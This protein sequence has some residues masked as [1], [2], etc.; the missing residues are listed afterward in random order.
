MVGRDGRPL[1]DPNRREEGLLLP[2][3]GAKG[4]GLALAI[5]LLAGTLNGAAL[6]RGVVDFTKET[7]SATNT[8]QFV[9]AIKL[10]AFADP[11]LFGRTVDAVFEQ[12]RASAPLPGHDPVRIPGERREAT[13]RER[14]AAGIP[15][16]PNLW[17]ELA[18]IAGELD[19]PLP[20]RSGR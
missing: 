17:K 4:Y 1:T 18:A 15:L 16:H 7:S 6:G 10:A 19:I 3:G 14:L 8:G 20:D 9:A 2:I 12:M 11:D 13:R 5:G